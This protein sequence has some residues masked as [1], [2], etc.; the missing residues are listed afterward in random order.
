VVLE[1]RATTGASAAPVVPE[2]GNIV[3][4]KVTRINKRACTVDIIQVGEQA[5]E[6]PFKGSVRLQD[7]RATEVDKVCNSYG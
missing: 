3:I 6:P 7:V 4:A 5:L 1:V 2:A